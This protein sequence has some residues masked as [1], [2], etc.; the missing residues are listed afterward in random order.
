M[1]LGP[2]VRTDHG[3]YLS[4]LRDNDGN[5][6]S[7]GGSG[8]WVSVTKAADEARSSTTLAVDSELVFEAEAGKAYE[9]EGMFVWESDSTTPD[10]KFAFGEDGTVRGG[11]NGIGTHP[12]TGNVQ[13]VATG[14]NRIG[15]LS[16]ASVSGRQAMSFWGVHTGAGGTFAVLW[17]C[18]NS[19]SVTLLAGSQ[20]RYRAVG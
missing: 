10:I 9:L 6:L 17:A 3:H 14:T 11:I 12:S 1:S 16:M 4:Q 7:V 13:L 8:D 2:R 18:I 19:G 20:I 5:P 15:T